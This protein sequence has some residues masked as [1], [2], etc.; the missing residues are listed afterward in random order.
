LAPAKS[1]V[2]RKKIQILSDGSVVLVSKR[3]KFGPS[4][5]DGIRIIIDNE[6]SEDDTEAWETRKL[7]DRLRESRREPG[8]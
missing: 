3:A 7:E 2:R 4:T 5:N 6:Y 8:L 1:R